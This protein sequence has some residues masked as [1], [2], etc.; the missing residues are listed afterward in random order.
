MEG[1]ARGEGRLRSSRILIGAVIVVAA[2]TYL[3]IAGFQKS[4]TYYMEVDEYL[5]R[6]A[7][8]G[9]RVVRVNG[10]VQPGTIKWES[11]NVLLKFT[12]AGSAGSIPVTFRGIRPDNFEDGRTVVVEGRRDKSGVFVARKLIIQCPSKYEAA[13]KG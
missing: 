9:E 7:E 2:I 1:I 4:T 12:L 3:A 8:F 11:S 13:P 6:A 10:S 5:N